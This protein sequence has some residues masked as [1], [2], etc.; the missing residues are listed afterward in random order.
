M[1]QPTKPTNKGKIIIFKK[2]I[3]EGRPLVVEKDRCQNKKKK[4]NLQKTETAQ[5]EENVKS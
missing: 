5:G 2:I 3:I 1:L 4:G